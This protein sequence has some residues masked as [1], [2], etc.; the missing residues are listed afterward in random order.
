M[1]AVGS[2]RWW[3]ETNDGVWG[4]SSQGR[5]A[6]CALCTKHYGRCS[7]QRFDVGYIPSAVC[8]ATLVVP[9]KLHPSVDGGW[10]TW[11]MEKEE[12][13]EDD[14]E[15]GRVHYHAAPTDKSNTTASPA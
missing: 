8:Q 10:W 15:A 13:D 6:N 11:Y 9:T 14:D 1:Q 7:T 5:W 3:G 4:L 2:L 12:L